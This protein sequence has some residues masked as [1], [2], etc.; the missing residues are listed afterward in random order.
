MSSIPKGFKEFTSSLGTFNQ[1]KNISSFGTCGYAFLGDPESFTFS[2][3]DFIDPSFMNRTR[4]TVPMILDW[5]IGNESCSAAEKSDGFAC[6]GNSSCLDSETG[7]G[8][9]RCRCLEGYEG[10]P[11]LSPGCTGCW[12]VFLLFLLFFFFFAVLVVVS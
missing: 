12:L 6:S 10:N 9:Y 7:L 4:D 2:G 3:F 5:A 11:Y 1:H 8:G